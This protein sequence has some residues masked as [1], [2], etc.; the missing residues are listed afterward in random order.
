MTLNNFNVIHLLQAFSGGIFHISYIK[1]NVP[2]SVLKTLYSTLVQPYL[3]YCNIVW[4]IHR[5]TA[6]NSLY[7]IQKKA[8]RTITS[9]P[10]NA[11]SAPLFHKLQILPIFN[12]NDLQLACF[13]Y[14]A[15]HGLL[16][17]YFINMFQVNSYIHTH[18]TR[19]KDKIHQIGHKLNLRKLTVT[20]AGPLLWNAL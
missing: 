8:V 10:R 3:E 5:S 7:L 17:F 4:A 14:S 15:T 2:L 20:V 1:K 6:L 18:D 19:Q 16:P 12:I 9:S 11:Y 13:I